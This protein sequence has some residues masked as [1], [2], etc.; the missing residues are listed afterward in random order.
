MSVTTDGSKVV[1]THPDDKSSSVTILNYGAT[2]TSWKLNGQEQLWLSDAAKLDGSKPV[3]GGIPLVFPVFGKS[4]TD[5]ALSKLPQH[6][7]ARNSTWE[8]LG[9]TRSNPPTVQFGLSPEIANEELTKLWPFDFSLV[10]TIELGLDFLKTA[11]E[12]NNPSKTEELKFNWLFHTYLRIEDIE[13]TFV[14]NLVGTKLYDQLLQE[15]Y[16]DKHPV[17]TFHEEKDLIYKNIDDERV[18]QVV[19]RGEPVHTIKRHNLPDTVVWN[20]WINKSNSMADFEPKTGYEKMVCVEPG[21]V[22]DLITLAPGKSWDG[23]Q[24]LYRDH[25]KYQAI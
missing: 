2:V 25:L 8:F 9:Q 11:I 12:V 19:R 23:Y 17:V 6:G 13:D 10:L 5:D 16:V 15:T 20:P 24:L 1:L 18:I 14:S 4:K 22:H 21:H 3:R 7:L